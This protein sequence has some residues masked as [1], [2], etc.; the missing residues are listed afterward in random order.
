M[1]I[2]YSPAQ[3]RQSLVLTRLSCHLLA[4]SSVWMRG[5]AEGWMSVVSKHIGTSFQGPHIG[6]HSITASVS[7][8]KLATLRLALFSWMLAPGPLL[9]LAPIPQQSHAVGGFSVY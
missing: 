3:Q 5:M 9:L 4:V 1:S 8:L 2:F 6:F 7:S